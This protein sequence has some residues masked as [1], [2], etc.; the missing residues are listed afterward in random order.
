MAA[1]GT[2]PDAFEPPTQHK[3]WPLLL[4]RSEHSFVGETNP[5][6]N[7]LSAQA[8]KHIGR[9]RNKALD[10]NVEVIK[11]IWAREMMTEQREHFQED[12]MYVLSSGGMKERKRVHQGDM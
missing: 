2:E 7:G 1:A 3:A 6:S 12:V 8:D 9:G 10:N 5:H 11:S 4:R